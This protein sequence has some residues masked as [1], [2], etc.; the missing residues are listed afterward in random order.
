MQDWTSVGAAIGAAIMGLLAILAQI[1]AVLGAGGAA[2]IRALERRIEHIEEHL[3]EWDARATR[4]ESRAEL[5]RLERHMEAQIE[6]VAREMGDRTC[7]Q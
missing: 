6:R 2:Q 4:E 7:R 5:A 1:R 3:I